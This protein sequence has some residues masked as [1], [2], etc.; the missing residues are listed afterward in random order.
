MKD[1][2]RGP[3]H[4]QRPRSREDL[5]RRLDALLSIAE[6]GLRGLSDD[7][8][9]ELGKLYRASATHLALVRTFGASVRQ[10]DELNR[11]VSRAHSVIYGRPPQGRN[12]AAFFLS[13]L[14]FPETVRRTWRYHVLAALVL[15]LGGL[16]GYLGAARDPEWALEFVAGD[17]RTPYASRVELHA[18]LMGGRPADSIDLDD[19]QAEAHHEHDVGEKAQFAAFLWQHNTKGALIALFSGFLLGLP[20]V[21]ILL[22]NGNLIGVYTQIFASHGLTYEWW[23]WILPHGITELGAVVLLAGGGLYVGHTVLVPG[24]RTRRDALREIRT[25]VTRLALFAFPMLFLAALIESFVRQSGIGDSARYVFAAATAIFW[26][27]YLGWGRL[28]E[29]A[30][31]F[32]KRRTIAERAVPL[33]VY[34][35]ILGITGTTQARIRT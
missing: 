9:E 11:L 32:A 22:L 35:E 1:T 12:A 21:L 16:Y 4:S 25:D 28:P 2:R 17:T 27:A 34:E 14:A 13:F 24:E 29:S 8:L 30:R 23:A 18:S 15:A 33:P 6:N 20:T 10:R 3:D 31:A 7:Q 19:A 26:T 5:W